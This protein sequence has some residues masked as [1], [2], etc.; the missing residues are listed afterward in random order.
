MIFF[1]GLG[2]HSDSS[3]ALLLSLFGRW[4]NVRGC[5]SAFPGHSILRTDI[6][7]DFT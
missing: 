2:E 3:R 7:D 6:V 1:I 4:F 5:T